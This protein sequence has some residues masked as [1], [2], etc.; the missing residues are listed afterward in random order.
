MPRGR[1]KQMNLTL[2][3]Q[4][5]AVEKEIMECEEQLKKLRNKKK[6]LKQQI[7]EKMK[8]ELY[9]A[10]KASGKKMEDVI[11]AMSDNKNE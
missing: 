8:E 3:E 11:A 10:F 4:L 2:E 7:E 5:T 6:D 1:K 9:S